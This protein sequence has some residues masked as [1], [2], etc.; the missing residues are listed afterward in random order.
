MQCFEAALDGARRQEARS[1]ELRAA[2]SKARLLIKQG[3]RP[4]AHA[5]LTPVIAWFTEGLDSHD[6]KLAKAVLDQA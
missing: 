3:R 4:D 5:L 1:L 6:M 2:T